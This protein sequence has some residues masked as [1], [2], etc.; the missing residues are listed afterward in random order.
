MAR[1]GTAR[2]GTAW[3]CGVVSPTP[4]PVRWRAGARVTPA[5]VAMSDS[6]GWLVGFELRRLTEGEVG[7]AVPPPSVLGN[8]QGARVAGCL[9]GG[10]CDC[11][12][13]FP[14]V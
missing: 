3:R 2:H 14:G 5:P 6:I 12:L 7:N 9:P 11:T 1:L 8:R 10:G 4:D 13:Y